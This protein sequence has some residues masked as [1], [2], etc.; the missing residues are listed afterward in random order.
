MDCAK[1]VN[2]LVTQGGRMEDYWG[3]GKAT[4]PMLPSIGV[5]TTAGTGSEMQSYALISKDETKVK[6]ACGDRKA[7]FRTV[8]LDPELTAT[9]PRS[10]AS[11][12]GIDAISHAVESYVSTRSNPISRPFAQEAWHILER[13]LP[14]ALRS[15]GDAL[16]RGRVQIGALLAGAAI[17]HSML[18]AAHA[19]ANPLTSRCGVAHGIAVGLM[20]PPAVRFNV[21]EVGELYGDLHRGTAAQS[22]GVGLYDRILELRALAGLPESLRDCG[23]PKNILPRLAAEAAEQWTA[24]FNPRPVAQPELLELYESAY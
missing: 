20:L 2:F 15:P 9:V 4:K 16:A 17:E 14:T 12:S 18:G 21:P 5:P 13:Y 11:V 7:R 8:V 6:M 23:V 19:C 1:G 10:V 22:R 3:S 24:G